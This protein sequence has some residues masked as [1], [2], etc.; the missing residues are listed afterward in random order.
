MYYYHS[1]IL[2]KFF[3]I[4]IRREGTT[5]DQDHLIQNTDGYAAS[6]SGI[7]E[8]EA[9]RLAE[10]LALNVPM[11]KRN[12]IPNGI[13]MGGNNHQIDKRTK[14]HRPEKITRKKDIVVFN[15]IKNNMANNGS[16]NSTDVILFY[17]A[18]HTKWFSD[19]LST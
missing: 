18:A 4:F 10:T 16:N 13:L 15:S 19:L 12:Y 3:N 7:D 17:N 5:E 11:A 14:I 6:G 9:Q 8:S 2:I 1:L